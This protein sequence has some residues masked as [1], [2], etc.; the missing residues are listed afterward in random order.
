MTSTAGGRPRSRLGLERAA[1][2]RIAG[3]GEPGAT[4]GWRERRAGDF[5]APAEAGRACGPAFAR[6]TSHPARGRAGAP[7]RPRCPPGLARA[8]TANQ[9][10]RYNA[11]RQKAEAAAGKVPGPS[12]R[13]ILAY[14]DATFTAA[15]GLRMQG[16]HAMLVDTDDAAA[17]DIAALFLFA[18]WIAIAGGTNEI[19]RNLL[20]EKNAR[21]PAGARPRTRRATFDATH[22]GR[23]Q[24]ES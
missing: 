8:Y 5:A 9:I 14:G 13:K 16:P 23:D 6:V 22:P 21:P 10:T 15:V 3:V 12:P 17:D 18:P 20:A 1:S 2:T 24:A 19:L 4:A 11:L 7:R